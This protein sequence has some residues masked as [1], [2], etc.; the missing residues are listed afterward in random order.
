MYKLKIEKGMKKKYSA[1]VQKLF[2]K[3]LWLTIDSMET[4]SKREAKQFYRMVAAY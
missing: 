1:K 4:D 3:R 2:F